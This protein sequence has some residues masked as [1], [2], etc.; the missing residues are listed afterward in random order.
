MADGRPKR[1]A[2]LRAQ[3]TIGHQDDEELFT[4]R[5]GPHGA[6]REFAGDSEYASEEEEEEAEGAGKVG[7]RTGTR[8]DHPKSSPPPRRPSERELVV[9]G[10]GDALPI[11]S[12]V[13]KSRTRGRPRKDGAPASAASS[14]LPASI[15]PLSFWA[16]CLAHAHPVSR[17]LRPGKDSGGQAF[18]QPPLDLLTILDPRQERKSRSPTV[19]I[20]PIRCDGVGDSRRPDDQPTAEGD[21]EI[22]VSLSPDTPSL[23]L[24]P[25]QSVYKPELGVLLLNSGPGPIS[26]FDFGPD[27][28][29][30]FAQSNL[31]AG[32]V[33]DHWALP[34]TTAAHNC[35]IKVYRLE[36]DPWEAMLATTI[37]HPF[38]IVRHLHFC[39]V[40]SSEGV[41]LLLAIFGDGSARVFGLPPL[42]A[43]TTLGARQVN[44]EVT[45]FQLLATSGLND[46]ALVTAGAWGPPPPSGPGQD[47]HCANVIKVALGC[48]DGRVSLWDLG[49]EGD[50]RCVAAERHGNLPVTSLAF[51]HSD[52][53]I[54]AV[55]LND[56]PAYI[57][58]WRS[59][60][61]ICPLHSPLANVPLVRWAPLYNCWLVADTENGLRAVRLQDF[62][63]RHSFPAGSFPLS[64]TA[65]DVSQLHNVL[66]TA[67]SDGHVHFSWLDPKSK[68]IALEQ[69]ILHLDSDER[70]LALRVAVSRPPLPS[71]QAAHELPRRGNCIP[72]VRWSPC[73][74]YPGLLAVASP[75]NGLLLLVAADRF[76]L[77][78]P[79]SHHR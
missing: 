5:E 55:G 8:P 45:D 7:G 49:P 19:A 36:A 33:D 58:D 41:F 75:L 57:I 62:A 59:P 16:D 20:T 65:Y 6:A 11:L 21:G 64:V 27:G 34:S 71:K 63:D 54:L 31:P 68:S 70:T 51:H 79:D 35:P 44:S 10:A 60:S 52:P 29:H 9:V 77:L 42:A 28:S 2:A 14:L 40:A 76:L 50:A 46:E 67:C 32:L 37:C 73:R 17:P 15:N 26:A 69:R 3:R 74:D 39:P 38:G 72:L 47:T 4:A 25:A 56:S 22:R 48:R 66:A 18:L 13:H 53:M 24:A 23:I 78:Q 30:L 43:A 1:A 12:I 61:R